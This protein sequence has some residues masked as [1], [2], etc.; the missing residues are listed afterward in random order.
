MS[1]LTRRDFDKLSL[2]TLA[3]L[4]L[5]A[6]GILPPPR[7]NTPIPTTLKKEGPISADQAL[8]DADMAELTEFYHVVADLHSIYGPKILNDS[9]AYC[10]RDFFSA[11]NTV[12]S[13]PLSYDK[14]QVEPFTS[15]KWGT[16]KEQMLDYS[17]QHLNNTISAGIEIP[18]ANIQEAPNYEPPTQQDVVYLLRKYHETFPLLSLVTDR[19]RTTRFKSGGGFTEGTNLT[20]LPDPVI[21]ADMFYLVLFHELMHG[22]EINYSALQQYMTLA[23]YS[24]IPT[25]L[26]KNCANVAR[27]WFSLS[28]SH[29]DFTDYG[30]ILHLHDDGEKNSMIERSFQLFGLQAKLPTE[31]QIS[32]SDADSTRYYKQD[33]QLNFVIHYLGNALMKGDKSI[34]DSDEKLNLAYT[35]MSYFF[36]ELTHYFVGPY[37]LNGGLPDNYARIGRSGIGVH[38]LAMHKVRMQ[39]F[40][41][42]RLKTHE[43][44][45]IRTALGL[46]SSTDLLISYGSFFQSTYE[47]SDGALIDIYNLPPSDNHDVVYLDKIGEYSHGS[48]IFIPKDYTDTEPPNGLDTNQF[49]EINLPVGRKIYLV[50]ENDELSVPINSIS[51]R[52][53]YMPWGYH[54]LN[55]AIDEEVND[56]GGLKKIGVVKSNKITTRS[57]ESSD[58]ERDFVWIADLNSVN[59]EHI[60]LY[61]K[62]EGIQG[63]INAISFPEFVPSWYF[64]KTPVVV[65]DGKVFHTLEQ[66]MPTATPVNPGM[67]IVDFTRE[68]IIRIGDD[69]NSIFDIRFSSDAYRKIVEFIKGHP[70]SLASFYFEVDYGKNQADDLKITLKLYA[71]K[72]TLITQALSYP[73]EHVTLIKAGRY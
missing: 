3:M 12:V 23:D 20:Q 38:N 6:C 55:Q 49:F 52:Q 26:M 4:A 22:A 73:V 66:I 72:T 69:Y 5:S 60:R 13:N 7:P 17:S 15:K 64:N 27:E 43:P 9:P 56:R 41:A 29:K 50:K 11:C 70:D 63:V 48:L 53:E 1:E 14:N 62:P 42:D 40:L 67:T 2:A 65:S 25:E 24:A 59:V 16:Q 61:P 33:Q 31:I 71:D 46:E 68:N 35:A 36:G 37:Q 54:L 28:G 8:K 30:F 47:R 21:N 44:S 10:A 45:E 34:I 19:Y 32:T 18:P 58:T 57:S 51:L 39:T